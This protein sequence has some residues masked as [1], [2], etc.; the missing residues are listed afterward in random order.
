M[1]NIYVE[2]LR[3]M[4]ALITVSVV[5]MPSLEGMLAVQRAGNIINGMHRAGCVDLA[6]ALEH[7]V[8]LA[9]AGAEYN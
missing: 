5:P 9:V 1:Y 8:P 4:V 3:A 6:K 2:F 7:A